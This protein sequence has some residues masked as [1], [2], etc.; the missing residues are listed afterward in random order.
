MGYPM[1]IVTICT[2]YFVIVLSLTRLVHVLRAQEHRMRANHDVVIST[3][4]P[5]AADDSKA[6]A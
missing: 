1:T 3:I 2:A 6:V 4:A 5:D